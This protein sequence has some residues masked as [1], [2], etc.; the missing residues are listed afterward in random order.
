MDW[1]DETAATYMNTGFA[2][3]CQLEKSLKNWVAN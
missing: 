1:P 2:E 3:H